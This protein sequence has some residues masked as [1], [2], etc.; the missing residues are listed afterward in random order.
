[1]VT[2]LH[3]QLP[4]R[5]LGHTCKLGFD[6]KEKIDC[7]YRTFNGSSNILQTMILIQATSQ[8]VNQPKL[9]CVC[10]FVCELRGEAAVHVCALAYSVIC[11]K[12]QCLRKVVIIQRGLDDDAHT[13]D[14]HTELRPGLRH[15]DTKRGTHE[16][17]VMLRSGRG[18]IL[19]AC[20]LSLAL[21]KKIEIKPHLSAF[22]GEIIRRRK[23]A[24][25]G[26]S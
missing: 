1:M 15:L 12:L 21:K 16:K 2:R 4:F 10:V 5:L 22:K 20:K 24:R 19:T 17:R 25:S 14:A 23:T 9:K 3:A 6:S 18:G 13:E 26:L 8:A 7:I 11:V